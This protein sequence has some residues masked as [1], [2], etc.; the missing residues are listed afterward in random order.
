MHRGLIKEIVHGTNV[1]HMEMLE[2]L[3][4]DLIDDLKHSDYH[5][6]K[7]IEYDLYKSVHGKHLNEKLAHKWVDELENKDG[8][9]GGHW[10]IEQTNQY[11]EANNRFD[12][13]VAMNVVYSDFYNPKFDTNMYVELAK[14]FIH[15]K[16]ASECKLLKY[17]MFVVKD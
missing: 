6:Y 11:A 7:E 9:K 16:D 10:T 5:K 12:W 17:Y 3:L 8:T 13:Y 1:E 4:V 2:K 15:D 14:D